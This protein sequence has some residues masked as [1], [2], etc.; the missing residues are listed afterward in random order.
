MHYPNIQKTKKQRI[1]G[2]Q[3]LGR[4]VV[5]QC[6][7]IHNRC[8]R[9]HSEVFRRIDARAQPII[10]II[11]VTVSL[12]V[13]RIVIGAATQVWALNIR[14]TKMKNNTRCLVLSV[15]CWLLIVIVVCHFARFQ[16]SQLGILTREKKA[17]IQIWYIVAM[18]RRQWAAKIEF[19]FLFC[20]NKS[21]N[22]NNNIVCN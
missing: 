20:E 2:V 18:I 6:I 21:K 3:V 19:K 22:N 13:E 9:A 8:W 4:L 1:D 15:W 11:I 5:T 12:S 17:P 14:W 10:I 16:C 7:N